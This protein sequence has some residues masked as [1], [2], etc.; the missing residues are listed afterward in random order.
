[1]KGVPQPR[2]AL[3]QLISLDVSRNF[4]RGILDDQLLFQLV[5]KW[6][7]TEFVALVHCAMSA[8][9]YVTS[10]ISWGHY[11]TGLPNDFWFTCFL[12]VCYFYCELTHPFIPN[13]YLSCNPFSFALPFC[14]IKQTHTLTLYQWKRSVEVRRFAQPNLVGGRL[15]AIGQLPNHATEPQQNRA[16]SAW[17]MGGSNQRYV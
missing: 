17:R 2:V 11:M 7:R 12:P 10:R 1:M 4:L 13:H 6:K 3:G 5:G 8:W 16:F 14:S 15:T 9:K